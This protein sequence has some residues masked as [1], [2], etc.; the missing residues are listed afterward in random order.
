MLFYKGERAA[1]VHCDSSKPPFTNPIFGLL[2][3]FGIL[4][5][6]LRFGTVLCD[7]N[8]FGQTKIDIQFVL[9]L[10]IQNL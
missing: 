3:C 5:C 10:I 2:K 6:N 4:S 9:D 1:Q 7:Q 8:K